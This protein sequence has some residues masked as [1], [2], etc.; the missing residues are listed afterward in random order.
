MK[1]SQKLHTDLH[2]DDAPKNIPRIPE[3]GIR[4]WGRMLG[5]RKMRG[6]GGRWQLS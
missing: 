1:K 2:T 4:G 6:G 5:E 3:Q